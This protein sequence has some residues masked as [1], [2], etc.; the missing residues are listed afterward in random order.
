MKLKF[1]HVQNF[2][3]FDFQTLKMNGYNHFTSIALKFSNLSNAFFNYNSNAS[4]KTNLTRKKFN[5]IRL[6]ELF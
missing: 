1:V 5:I 2:D 6:K 4:M 3:T